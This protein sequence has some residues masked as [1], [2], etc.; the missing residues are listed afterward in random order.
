MSVKSVGLVVALSAEARALTGRAQPVA[1]VVEVAERVFLRVGG[2]GA[3]AAE[4]SCAALI[5][6]GAGALVSV[7]C[8][9]GL[10]P[11]S[12]PGT[13]VVPRNVR[14]EQGAACGADAEWRAALIAVLEENLGLLSGD[15]VSVDRVLELTQKQGLNARTGAIAA[16]MESVTIA[17]AA[18][19]SELP[20]IAVRVVSD[21]ADDDVPRALLDTIDEFGRPSYGALLRAAAQRPAEVAALARL[22]TGF[23]R[24][25]KTLSRVAAATGLAFC[26]PGYEGEMGDG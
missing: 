25:C 22:Q 20:M 11:D 4:A 8:A 14:S 2:V 3:S 17:H 18:R 5:E 7:G 15:I 6:A 26:C 1:R 23:R 13:L 21:G 12:R 24:A 10:T 16:D 9:A 19:R